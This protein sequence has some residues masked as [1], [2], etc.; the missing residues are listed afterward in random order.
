MERKEEMNQK[1]VI[2]REAERTLIYLELQG[3]YND[4]NISSLSSIPLLKE[5]QLQI[6]SQWKEEK[7]ETE[8]SM[9][10]GVHISSLSQVLSSE[11]TQV[12]INVPPVLMLKTEKIETPKFIEDKEIGRRETIMPEVCVIPIPVAQS[13]VIGKF[14]VTEEISVSSVVEEQIVLPETTDIV[15]DREGLEGKIKFQSL[16]VSKPQEQMGG[17]FQPNGELANISVKPTIEK[18][19]DLSVNIAQFSMEELSVSESKVQNLE[20]ELGG[21]TDNTP[22]V[23]IEGEFAVKEGFEIERIIAPS[24]ILGLEILIENVVSI[25]Q[26][27]VDTEVST[28]EIMEQYTIENLDITMVDTTPKWILNNNKLE[29][30]GAEVSV[31]KIGEIREVPQVQIQMPHDISCRKLHRNMNGLSI[32]S[33]QMI[34]KKQ[35]YLVNEPYIVMDGYLSGIEKGFSTAVIEPVDTSQ[36]TVGKFLIPKMPELR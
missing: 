23:Q 35:E 29:W 4:D 17:L 1:E 33:G 9:K 12:E 14:E 16:K 18:R 10:S 22:M 25:E 32:W 2:S 36:I 24:N 5:K 28:V 11:N 21:L 30:K 15:I 19:Y 3:R 31:E 7:F 26:I 8:I 20:I 6:E 13:A 27:A 34:E